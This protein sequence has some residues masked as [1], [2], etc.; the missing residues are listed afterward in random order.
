MRT[1]NFSM[2]PCPKT[3]YLSPI[4]FTPMTKIQES[5]RFFHDTLPAGVKLIAVSKTHPESMIREALEAGQT[6]F[7]ENK[8]QE[9]TAKHRALAD[10]AAAWHCIGHLQTNKVKDIAPFVAMIHSVDSLHLL[11]EIEKQ[12]ARCGRIVPCLLQ[13]HIAQEESKFGFS[14]PELFETI[15]SPA[16]QAMPHVRISGLMGIA[17]TTDDSRQI[18]REFA[19]LRKLFQKLKE[20]H[21]A[22]SD[23]FRELSMGLSGD[24]RIAVE[25]GSTM[26]RIGSLIFGERNYGPT[27]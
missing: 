12:A 22:G 9:M 16:L 27:A 15:S 14:E 17:S 11:S 4:F 18:G 8:M 5:I 7:G 20:E 13:V 1:R 24:Y 10:T 25:E 26:V 23:G 2:P 19:H 21:F 6:D 3:S